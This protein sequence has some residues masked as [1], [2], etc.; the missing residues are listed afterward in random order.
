MKTATNRVRKHWIAFIGFTLIFM[1]CNCVILFGHTSL[2][3]SCKSC[4]LKK[5]SDALQILRPESAIMFALGRGIVAR[6]SCLRSRFV[7]PRVL[8]R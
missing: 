8:A 4:H 6:H 1:I 7:T 3:S 2:L 5:E